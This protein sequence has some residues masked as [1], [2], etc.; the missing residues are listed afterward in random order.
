MDKSVTDTARIVPVALGERSYDIVIGAG[1]IAMLGERLR[2][3][4]KSNRVAVI[5]DETVN[6]LH[7]P[8]IAEAL[9]D[10]HTHMIVRPEGE[11]QKSM[12]GLEAVLDSLFRAGLDRSDTIL[13]FGGGVMG[14]LTGFAA[15][16]YKRGATFVQVPTT[17]LAQ[18]DSSVGG[19]TAINNIYGKNLVGAFYQP[20][21]VLI[22][23]DFLSTL[24]E[25]QVKAGY[26]EILKYG[27]IDRPNFFDVLDNGL[28][29]GLGKRL[30]ALN[31]DAL[32]QA[33]SVSCTAKADVVAQDEREGG[34][35]ALLNLGHTFAHALELT[36]GYDGDLLHGEAVSAGMDMA[37]EFSARLGICPEAA[38]IQLKDHL[39]RL[40]MPRREDMAEFLTD[41]D[42]LL[43]HMRQD[44]KN[45]DGQ[46]TL[47][48][49]RAIGE[50]FIHR[51]VDEAEL[52]SYLKD[53]TP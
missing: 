22:D 32:T 10:F 16:I 12:A 51:G 34:V 8:A 3:L 9:A 23:T 49:A 47:I 4:T 14:D 45:S 2:G 17:L 36:A 52:L 6:A 20:K 11:D 28:D 31:P 38:S 41:P 35:R 21:L 48:L 46:I 24:P 33:I 37:F 42:S 15:S 26:A 18:V 13:A 19:K 7:G 30:L 5:T 27:L 43:T 39:T 44:K 50:S 1:T 53:I 25:R 40:S 29:N